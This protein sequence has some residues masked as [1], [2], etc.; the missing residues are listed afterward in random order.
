MTVLNDKNIPVN[1]F[2][3][4]IRNTFFISN[5]TFK[6]PLLEILLLGVSFLFSVQILPFSIDVTFSIFH[7]ATFLGGFITF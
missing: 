6:T 3:P 1:R 4:K 7:V 2:P 5:K